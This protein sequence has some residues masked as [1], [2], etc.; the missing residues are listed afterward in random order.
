MT[1]THK[2]KLLKDL[3]NYKAGWT[4]GWDGEKFYPYKKSE[5]EFDNGKESIYLDKNSQGYSVEE[6][7]DTTWFEPIGK[8]V[9]FIPKFPS[10]SKIDEFVSLD[11]ETKL[12]NQVDECRAMNNLFD[13]KQFKDDLY[14]FVK[15]KYDQFYKLETYKGLK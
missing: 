10:K 13:N 7:K 11:F 12:I 9:D 6:I 1:F 8:E 5:W 15:G 14:S 2:Y 3:P 4:L